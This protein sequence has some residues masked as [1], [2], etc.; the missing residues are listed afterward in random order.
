MAEVLISLVLLLLETGAFP[1]E[2]LEAS[3]FS[4]TVPTLVFCLYI[5]N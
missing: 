1:Q 5:K 4:P 3:V 2:V